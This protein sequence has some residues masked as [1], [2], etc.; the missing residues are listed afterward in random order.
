MAPRFLLSENYAGRCGL[1]RPTGMHHRT[2]RTASD[3]PK[4]CGYTHSIVAFVF[5]LVFYASLQT[6]RLKSKKLFLMLPPV[7]SY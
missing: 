2:K 1:P 3:M 4:P 7:I 6:C 5:Y